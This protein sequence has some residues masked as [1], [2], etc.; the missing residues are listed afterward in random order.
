MNTAV[1]LPPFPKFCKDVLGLD[2]ETR[3]PVLA[4]LAAFDGEPLRPG[5]IGVL[6]QYTGRPYV[7]RQGGYRQGVLQVGRQAGKSE[8]SAARIVYKAAEAVLQDRRNRWFVL[9]AQDHRAGQRA[10]FGYVKRFC[11]RPLICDHVKNVTTDTIEMEGGVNIAVYPCRPA[12]WRGLRIDEFVMDECAHFR[13]SEQ[14]IA[15]DRECWRSALPALAMTGGKLLALSSPYVASGL[16]YDLHRKHYGRPDSDLLF[17]VSP[18]TVLNPK[19]DTAYLDQLRDL[20]PEGARAEIDGE[21]LENTSALLDE[22]KI[23]GAVDEGVTVRPREAGR[24]YVAFMDWATGSKAGNDAATVAIGHR[25][26]GTAI[27]DAL[28]A[29]LPPFSPAQVAIEASGLCSR[30]GISVVVG[31]RFSQ[32]FTDEAC[33]RAGLQYRQCDE[34][35]SALYVAFAAGVNAGE[36]RLLDQPDLLREI[37]GLERRRTPTRDKVDHRPG[38]HDDRAN[39]CAGVIAQLLKVQRGGFSE[40]FVHWL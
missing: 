12:S 30:Y 6:E 13:S 9:V 24:E 8:T 26:K 28:Q 29:W 25:E 16:L 11:E 33:R 3:G 31:D 22:E 32:G 15:L 5:Q 19:L 14:G 38:A 1:S 40:S 4:Y 18:S 39:A 37:R 21:F 10:L 7:P 35:K 2:T 20:D 17:W 36:V 34:D 27:L 23:A